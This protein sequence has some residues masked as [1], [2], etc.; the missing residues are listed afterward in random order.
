MEAKFG[1]Q[2]FGVNCAPYLAIGTLLRLVEDIQYTYLIASQIL[3]DNMY[4]DNVLAGAHTVE[5]TEIAQE[6]LIVALESAGFPLRKWTSNT[7]LF[8]LDNFFFDA[9]KIER[10]L[11]YTK[12]AVLSDIAKLFDPAG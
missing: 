9:P 1:L 5:E 4:V 12:R 11:A 8:L 3:R 6:Q 7:Q 2:C 10:K